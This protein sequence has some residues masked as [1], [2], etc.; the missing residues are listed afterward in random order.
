MT[1]RVLTFRYIGEDEKIRDF[2]TRFLRTW[3]ELSTSMDILHC[4][5]RDQGS[6]SRQ[7]YISIFPLQQEN[8]W[9]L[10]K[11][12]MKSLCSILRNPEHSRM[13][14]EMCAT[15][16]EMF[17]LCNI[18]EYLMPSNWFQIRTSLEYIAGCLIQ[19]HKIHRHT[20]TTEKKSFLSLLKSLRDFPKYLDIFLFLNQNKNLHI[21]FLSN[22]YLEQRTNLHITELNSITCKMDVCSLIQEY[23]SKL[24]R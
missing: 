20:R 19:N 13:Y 3:E 7:L 2:S 10:N 4:I 22:Y 1:F 24:K 9:K 11:N 23:E 8:N 12:T 17:S 15:S 21:N 5:L 18:L 6:Q 14:L 16:V